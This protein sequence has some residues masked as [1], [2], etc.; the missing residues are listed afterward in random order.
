MVVHGMILQVAECVAHPVS[1]L[2]HPRAGSP[3][4]VNLAVS[5]S[6]LGHYDPPEPHQSPQQ[7]LGMGSYHGEHGIRRPV[8]GKSA[9]EFIQHC[10]QLRGNLSVHRHNYDRVILSQGIG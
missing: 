1:Y 2:S 7:K 6:W 5:A 3:P 9:F 8:S 4:G 10:S